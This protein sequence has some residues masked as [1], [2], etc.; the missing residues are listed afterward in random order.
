MHLLVQSLDLVHIR[1]GARA[2]FK[3]S[4]LPIFYPQVPG[5]AFLATP[6]LTFSHYLRTSYICIA[7][8][9]ISTNRY[10]HMIADHHKIGLK[11]AVFHFNPPL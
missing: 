1:A 9:P 10:V 2:A 4:P 3:S 11:I 8:K 5:H 7:V 6:A